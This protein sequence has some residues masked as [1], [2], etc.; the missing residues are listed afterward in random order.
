MEGIMSVGTIDHTTLSKLAEAGAVRSAHVVAQEGGWEILV[1]FGKTE[2]ILTAQRSHQARIFRKFE[3]LVNYL[4]SIGIAHFDVDAVNYG[5][6]GIT[7]RARPDQAA[8]MKSA[9]QAATYDEFFRQQV[10]NALADKRPSL[11]T[12]EA[13]QRIDAARASLLNKAEAKS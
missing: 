5:D 2:Q 10:Q 4:K 6:S 12:V 3:T 1:K 9:H 11:S 8:K 13:R 7:A